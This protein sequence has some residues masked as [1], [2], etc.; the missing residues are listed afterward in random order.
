MAASA[1]S[2]AP[3]FRPGRPMAGRS[4]PARCRPARRAGAANGKQATAKWYN[5]AFTIGAS[6]CNYA[7]RENFLDLD[8]TYRD[9]LGRPLMRMSYNFRDNDYKLADYVG[10]VLGRLAKAM[11]P[12]VMSTPSVKKGDYSVV[13]YQST[14]NTGGTMTGPI[15]RPAS[16]TAICNPGTPTICSSWAPRYFRRTPHTIRPASSARSP[17]GRRMRSRRNISRTPGRWCTPRRAARRWAAPLK[18][19]VL[20]A[21]RSAVTLQDRSVPSDCSNNSRRSASPHCRRDK[22]VMPAAMKANSTAA[23][24]Q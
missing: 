18:S 14:H 23:R 22:A 5:H 9:A 6:G 19:Y 8:P 12:T 1:S 20:N 21:V 13:P 7:H 2:A 10:G 4:R 15:R 16:S 17:I 11:N 24:N 3:G